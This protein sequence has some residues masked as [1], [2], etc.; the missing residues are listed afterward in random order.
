MT[1]QGRMQVWSQTTGIFILRPDDELA[2]G[3]EGVVYKLTDHPDLVAKIYHPNRRTADAINKLKVMTDRPPQARDVQ[4]GHLFVA[5]PSALVYDARTRSEV[6]GF[7]MPKVEKTGSLFDY[8]TPKRRRKESS[9]IHYYN[10]CSVAKSLATALARLHSRQYVV[11]DINESNAYITEYEHATLLDA[12]SFQVTDNQTDPPTIYRCKVG[13]PEYTPPE[14]QDKSFAEVNRDVDHD[15]FALAVVIYQLL[16]EGAHPFSGIYTGLGEKPSKETCISR[17]YFTHS[18]ARNVPLTPAPGA[19][20][21]ET[22]PEEIRKLFLKC[23]D[24]GHATPHERPAPWEWE[25]A[26]DEAINSLAQCSTN[27]SHWYFSNNS[28]CI[29]CARH[30]TIGIDTFPYHPDAQ[31]GPPS[32]DTA[33][34]PSASAPKPAPARPTAEELRAI[35]QEEMANTPASQPRG[36]RKVLVWSLLLAASAVFANFFLLGNPVGAIL[37][38]PPAA[39]PVQP[40]QP[41]PP[42]PPL[43][44]VAVI[45]PDT[46]IPTNTPTIAPTFTPRPPNT[47]IPAAIVPTNTPIPTNTPTPTA[48]PTDTPTPR[49]T[50][51]PSPTY[52][53][54]HTPIPTSTHTPTPSSTSTPSSTPTPIPTATHT[55]S[56]T[57]TPTYTPSPC[58]HFGPGANLNRCDL[59]GRDFRGFNLTGANLAYANL[60]GTNLKDAVLTNATIAGASVAGIDLTNVDLSTTDITGVHT[61][62]KA[63]LIKVTFPAGADLSDASFKDADLSRSFIVGANLER[64]DFTG[65]KLYRADLTGAVLADANFRRADIDDAIVDGA[66]LQRANLASA[67]F[68]EADF[69]TNPDFRGADLRNASFFKAAL[70]GVDFTGADLEEANFNRAEMKATIFVNAEMNE[71]DMQ[72]ADA[73]GARFDGADVSDMDFS[74]SD[75]KSASFHG[76]NIEGARFTEA[77]LTGANFSGALNADR[78]FFR[79]TICSDGT[80]SSSC[81]FEGRLHGV[82][83]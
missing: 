24:N 54:T 79:E 76:A 25:S 47:P 37:S 9:Q 41:V 40:A 33:S 38:P 6:V 72:D 1:N 22:L 8:Y 48:V 27:T 69:D 53:A 29:W 70:G 2:R 51:T 52:T 57:P 36:R 3:G 30:Q 21:W 46:P 44:A 39:P 55:A 32:G 67:D 49:P 59:S 11:G 81:Y 26:L 10:L 43:P 74:E 28:T 83:P 42:L 17:G 68:S 77:D 56:P 71:A 19:L 23:F 78:A 20:P 5:W 13:K 31:P 50:L 82:G 64:A 34:V 12:D 60:T 80:M 75:L 66:N 63:I 4:T 45:P 61:F 62:D 15:S 16:M 58:L 14:L 73:Q 65:A 35:I 7:L 18:A